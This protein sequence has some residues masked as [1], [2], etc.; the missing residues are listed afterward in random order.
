MYKKW[1]WVCKLCIIVTK[2]VIFWGVQRCDKRVTVCNSTKIKEN[3]INAKGLKEKI[4]DSMLLGMEKNEDIFVRFLCTEGIGD[5]YS[6][7]AYEPLRVMVERASS[8][9]PKLYIT[10]ALA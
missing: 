5:T 7:R 6:K 10:S 3:W 2:I 9:L 8:A 1:K 4:I